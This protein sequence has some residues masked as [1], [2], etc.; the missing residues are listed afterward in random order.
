MC[1]YTVVNVM[2]WISD[3][4]FI[5]QAFTVSFQIQKEFQ[6]GDTG[7]NVFQNRNKTGIVRNS[8]AKTVD[9]YKIK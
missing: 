2:E 6:L 3:H 4:A 7:W 8:R 5:I 9:S 1:I